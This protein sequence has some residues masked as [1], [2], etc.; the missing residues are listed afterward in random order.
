[1]I[2]GKD[3]KEFYQIGDLALLWGA[4]FARHVWDLIIVGNRSDLGVS[5]RTHDVI[6]LPAE[7]TNGYDSLVP[8]KTW[9][10]ILRIAALI[11]DKEGVEI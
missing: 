3:G 7:E 5:L 4:P 9:P 6:D 8:A 11:A 1:M 10:D 2:L